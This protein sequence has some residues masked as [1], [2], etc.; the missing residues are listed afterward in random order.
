MKKTYL[1]IY[2]FFIFGSIANAQHIIEPLNPLSEARFNFFKSTVIMFNEYLDTDNGTF[3]TTNIRVLKPL[4]SRKWN[5]RADLPIVSTN[6]ISINKTGLGDI[7]FAA[8][9]IPYATKKSALAFRGKITSNSA[10][11]SSFGSGKWVFTP[12]LFW[13]N[14][15]D[16]N[17]KFLL[18]SSIENQMSFAGSST[19]SKVNTTVLENVL[20]YSFGKNWIGTN[21]A[22]RY[23]A[24]VDGFQ[25]SSFLEYGRKFTPDSMFYIH[26]SIAYG[27]EKSYNNGIE[28]GLVILY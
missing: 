19:R 13:G 24:T 23:N 4:S 18:I 3:N 9:Y 20:I 10:S 11:D 17:K 16:S 27:G 1:I 15:L 2:C 25:N 21:V 22:L 28:V 6:T 5:F 8:S 12:T 26:P 14:Y 7:S